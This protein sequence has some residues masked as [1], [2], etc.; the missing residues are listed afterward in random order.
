M[1]DE[2]VIRLDDSLSVLQRRPVAGASAVAWDPESGLALSTRQGRSLEL[3]GPD[4]G[5]TTVALSDVTSL[6]GPVQAELWGQL[7]WS[8]TAPCWRRE[9]TTA[10]CGCWMQPGGRWRLSRVTRRE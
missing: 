10:R 4:G 7:A 1:A 6:G 5:R 3:T 8:R 9:P 2:E